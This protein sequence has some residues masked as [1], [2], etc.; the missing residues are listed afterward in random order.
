[1]TNQQI[2][3]AVAD[4]KLRETLADIINEYGGH[5]SLYGELTDDVLD[6]TIYSDKFNQDHLDVIMKHGYYGLEI[7]YS[8]KYNQLKTGI[9]C[10]RREIE[11]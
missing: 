4:K 5:L 8:T 10:A 3:S 2:V 6:I 11:S 1:M 9:E 7:T